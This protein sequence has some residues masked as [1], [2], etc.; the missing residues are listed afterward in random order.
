[1]V[2]SIQAQLGCFDS[3]GCRDGRG[4][5]LQC[6]RS[7]GG[8]LECLLDSTGSGDKARDKGDH[9]DTLGG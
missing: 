7:L 8:V 9:D 3:G 1:M 4:I 5:T 2:T 6:G